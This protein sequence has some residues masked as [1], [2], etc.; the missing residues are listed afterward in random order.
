MRFN[1]FLREEGIAPETVAVLLHT[2]KEASLRRM[3]PW[4]AAEEPALFHAYQNN[5]RRGVEAT[6]RSRRFLASFVAG[7]AADMIFA[8]LFEVAGWERWDAGRFAADPATRELWR[9][10]GW[11]GSDDRSS[12]EAMGDRL[13]FDLRPREELSDLVG[14]LLIE[15]PRSRAYARL[16]ETFDAEVVEVARQSRLTP[17]APDWRDLILTGGEVRTLPRDWAS[18]LAEWRGIYLIVD[19][20][21]GARYVGSAYGAENL[22]G[23]WRAHVAGDRGVTAE[24]QR[25]D[26][27]RFRFSILE[28]VS[29][30]LPAEEVIRLEQTW[31]ERLDTRR[32][33]LNAGARAGEVRLAERMVNV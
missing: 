15:R 33:G 9:R 32:F 2:P 8:G 27:V 12:G 11:I 1:V 24:L 21:D 19:E 7:P 20:G 14:R 10:V 17:G 16:A 18:R 26:P 5:H 30:D 3:L 31:M 29:P 22:L 23:R 25:R 6:V 4:L 13:V 28:R